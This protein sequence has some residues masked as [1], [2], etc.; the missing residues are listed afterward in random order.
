MSWKA[1]GPNDIV[2]IPLQD[3]THARVSGPDHCLVRIFPWFW[4]GKYVK[5]I[6]NGE[7]VN[8][9]RISADTIIYMHRLICGV[10]GEAGEHTHVDHINGDRRNNTRKNIEVVGRQVNNKRRDARQK[11]LRIAAK[12]AK[13]HT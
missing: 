5:C 10:H 11:A 2:L 3:G 6:L 7:R 1:I 12:R 9:K 13:R 4:D 8:G